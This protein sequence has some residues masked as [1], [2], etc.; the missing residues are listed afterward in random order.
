M[1]AVKR[2]NIKNLTILVAVR[3]ATS[4]LAKFRC[5]TK[6]WKRDGTDLSAL[7]VAKCLPQKSTK[8]VVEP[9]I[10]FGYEPG[11]ARIPVPLTRLLRWQSRHACIN[12][13]ERNGGSFHSFNV[14]VKFCPGNYFV[15]YLAPM[16]SCSIAYCAGKISL[17]AVNKST[18]FE[19]ETSTVNYSLVTV[20]VWTVDNFKR[21]SA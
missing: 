4:S 20:T 17:K 3:R 9:C 11:L 13:N 12:I 5:A 2:Q 18:M 1:T 16:P 10:Q 6:I 15:Y 7:S 8:I 21:L 19:G 14:G